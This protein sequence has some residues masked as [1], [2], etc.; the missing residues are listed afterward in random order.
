[1]EIDIVHMQNHLPEGNRDYID[2][3]RAVRLVDTDGQICGELIWRLAGRWDFMFEATPFPFP[4]SRPPIPALPL[5][6]PLA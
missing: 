4:R 2:G 6:T 3:Y 5:R 1:V